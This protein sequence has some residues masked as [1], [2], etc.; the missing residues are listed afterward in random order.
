MSL[1][2][3]YGPELTQVLLWTFV[4]TSAE[5]GPRYFTYFKPHTKVT[6]PHIKVRDL[7]PVA[8]SGV[9][10]ASALT[11]GAGT[12]RT[13]LRAPEPDTWITQTLSSEPCDLFLVVGSNGTSVDQLNCM[14][15]TLRAAHLPDEC[16]TWA[17]ELNSY[18]KPSAEICLQ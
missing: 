11:A 18:E 6:K 13:C 9:A 5:R 17:A 3:L 7:R 4:R 2:I 16:L 10:L 12:G 1:K 15:C 8:P 14:G